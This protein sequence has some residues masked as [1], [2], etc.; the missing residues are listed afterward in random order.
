MKDWH[1]LEAKM[2]TL[3]HFIK[4]VIVE[5]DMNK[6]MGLSG[7][8]QLPSGHHKWCYI[9]QKKTKKKKK[10]LVPKIISSKFIILIQ[11]INLLVSIKMW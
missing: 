6:S 7:N 4:T 10:L 9:N 8:V 1:K 3:S 11:G 5:D 2:F